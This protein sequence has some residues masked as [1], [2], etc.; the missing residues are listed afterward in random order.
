M[1]AK[2]VFCSPCAQ[3]PT[4]LKMCRQR[5]PATANAVL[6]GGGAFPWV[7]LASPTSVFLSPLCGSQ[8]RSWRTRP[9]PSDG[10]VPVDAHP[11]SLKLR[12]DKEARPSHSH[13]TVPATQFYAPLW[14]RSVLKI[15]LGVEILVWVGF[16]QYLADIYRPWVIADFQ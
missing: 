5:F 8:R 7:A 2:L 4:G 6:I 3:L 15:D 14:R 11:P 10:T 13:G 16:I 9:S 12:R 1:V